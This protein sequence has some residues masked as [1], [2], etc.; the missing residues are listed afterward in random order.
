MRI[1][2]GEDG[3]KAVHEFQCGKT[4]ITCLAVSIVRIYVAHFDGSCLSFENISSGSRS[5]WQS[6][7]SIDQPTK[8]HCGPVCGIDA[9]PYFVYSVGADSTI[10]VWDAT[11]EHEQ[12]RLEACTAPGDFH[13]RSLTGV[14]RPSSRWGL[15]RG[16]N[17]GTKSPCGLLCVTGM[18]KRAEGLLMTWNLSSRVCLHCVRAHDGL[19]TALAF[20]PYDNGPVLTGG[21]DMCI[22]VWD[23]FFLR[24]IRCI[25]ANSAEIHGLAVEPQRRF[26][27]LAADGILKV[28]ALM[29]DAAHEPLRTAASRG[30]G[31]GPRREAV[32]RRTQS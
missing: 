1:L 25:G 18:S 28:W 13:I 29:D 7:A 5:T 15:S 19:I 23:L 11:L 30:P 6:Q 8:L 9:D 20:G 14:L 21:E 3:L 26:Y 27:S 4:E 31:I 2:D 10:S 24:C 16:H 12:M 32:E 22:R 17:R